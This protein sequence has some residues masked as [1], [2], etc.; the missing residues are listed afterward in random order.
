MEKLYN[1]YLAYNDQM[2][3]KCENCGGR[4]IFILIEMISRRRLPKKLEDTINM[5]GLMLLIGLSA[6]IMV[7]DFLTIIF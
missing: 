4:I 7:K 3:N 1:K 2:I 5:V 6:I